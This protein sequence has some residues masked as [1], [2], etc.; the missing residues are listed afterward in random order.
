MLVCCLFCLYLV[1]LLVCTFLT[2]ARHAQAGQD[3]SPSDRS[4]LNK[5]ELLGSQ[6]TVT[7]QGTYEPQV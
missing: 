2:L 3:F 5:G 6:V 1:V 7:A 4:V